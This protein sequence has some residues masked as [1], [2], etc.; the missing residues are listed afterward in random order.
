MRALFIRQTSTDF[1]YFIRCRLPLLFFHVFIRKYELFSQNNRVSD[2]QVTGLACGHL[3]I[4]YS[5][6]TP[7][8]FNEYAIQFL[9]FIEFIIVKLFLRFIILVE[10]KQQ[11]CTSPTSPTSALPEVSTKGVTYIRMIDALNHN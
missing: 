3:F 2:T 9:C 7:N 4:Y 5:Q 1:R 11:I 8:E 10:H 6:R